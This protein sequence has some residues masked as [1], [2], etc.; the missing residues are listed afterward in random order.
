MTVSGSYELE[1]RVLDQPIPGSPLPFLILSSSP[2][3]ASSRL[4][5]PSEPISLGCETSL[6]LRASDCYGNPVVSGGV[7]VS[8]RLAGGWGGSVVVEEGEDGLFHL[9]LTAAHEKDD[10]L[11]VRLD[12]KEVLF[13]TSP[14]PRPHE[15]RARMSSLD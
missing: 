3:A 5:P 10:K 14:A 12:G 1:L 8:A 11:V 9:R 6:L 13:Q 2:H 4:T 15:L 7:E